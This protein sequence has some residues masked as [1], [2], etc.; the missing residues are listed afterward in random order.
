MA[1]TKSEEAAIIQFA[2]K[3]DLVREYR[4]KIKQQKGETELK[5]RTAHITEEGLCLDDA[6]ASAFFSL[7]SVAGMCYNAARFTEKGTLTTKE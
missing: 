6:Q 3:G 4:G 2:C 1:L 7:D 5:D